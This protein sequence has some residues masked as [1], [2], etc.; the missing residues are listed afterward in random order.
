M[1]LVVT[2][3]TIAVGVTLTPERDV[4]LSLGTPQVTP[5]PLAPPPDTDT[6][7]SAPTFDRH[8]H[9][10]SDP[11]SRWVVV[12]KRHGLD[13]AYA[14]QLT[15]VRGVQVAAVAAPDLERMLVAADRLQL[16]LE[17]VS[18]HR[19]YSHQKA[20]YDRAV[21]NR[22]GTAADAMSARPGHS[23]HQTGLAVDVRD[24]ATPECT[25]TA[26]FGDTAAGRWVAKEGWRYGFVVRY[27]GA[28]RDVTGFA[29]EPWHL[30]W[31][32]RPL[33]RELRR[34]RT[35][36]LEEFFDVAGGDYANAR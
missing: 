6:V 32:G 29:H 33:A 8:R 27:T 14:P 22:G 31:V 16:D 10:T 13:P 3:S 2:A 24:T 23:E 15:Q 36:S 28:N 21:A 25:L 19:A 17:L 11:E 26:C 35:D 34:T 9:S 5:A 20:V 7:S 30:R 1:A 12:N 4:S 18:G